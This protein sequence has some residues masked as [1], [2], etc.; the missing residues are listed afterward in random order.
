[1][2]FSL[3]VVMAAFQPLALPRTLEELKEHGFFTYGLDERGAMN[4]GDVPKDGKRV[5]VLGA[6][7]SGLRRLVAENCDE[8]VKLPTKPPIA[9]LNVS[10]AAAVGLYALL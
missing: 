2:A 7:G 10:N 8:L 3:I 9:S 1:M 5:L 6:E 4:I